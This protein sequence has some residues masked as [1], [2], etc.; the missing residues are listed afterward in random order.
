MISYNISALMAHLGCEKFPERWKD[1]YADAVSIYENGEN[2]LLKP[3]YYDELHKKYKV[4]AN[5]LPYY[6]GATELLATNEELSLFFCLLC[7]ALRD[8]NVILNDLTAL[9]FPKAPEGEDSLPYDMITALAICQS[10]PD[11]YLKMKKKN[12]PDDIIFDTLK[13]PEKCV[14]LHLSEGRPRLSS[15]DWYQL[16]YDGMLF[17]I[18]RL[19]L[20]F[21]LST[22]NLY[23]IFENRNGE[24]VSL[25]NIK[26][27]RDGFALGALH[28]EDEE[29][30]FS[31]DITENE[32]AFIGHPYDSLGHISK[33]KVTLSKKEWSVKLTS[34]DKIVGLHIPPGG[35][36]FG[37]NVIEK[38]LADSREFMKKYFPEY[39][40][41]AFFC[42]SWLV[43]PTLSTLLGD[44]ANI[45]KFG[46][47]FIPHSVKSVG[48]SPFV[49]VYHIYENH[50]DVDVN[51][52]PEKSRLQKLLKKHYLD[53]NAIYDMH[54]IFF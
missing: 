4:F 16:A 10:Y 29:G 32:D 27:H 5:T 20:E 36:P 28:Y 15:F 51:V 40:Y 11:L 13:I 49:Y 46:K 22:P 2:P 18:G 9:S 53:G 43:D 41:K 30:A 31:A 38:T 34:G 39:E 54:G 14:E 44:D 19:Q 42:A 26:V 17:R 48:R 52:L 50:A 12:I 21:P 23:K 7:R 47:R 33:N 25:A 6:K 37:D 8:R 3:E 24:T 45:S 1:I 35:E